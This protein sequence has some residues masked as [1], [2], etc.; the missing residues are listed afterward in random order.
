MTHFFLYC[1]FACS[2]LLLPNVPFCACY[3]LIQMCDHR[4][5][6]GVVLTQTR[7]NGSALACNV[8]TMRIMSCQ[9]TTQ[10]LPSFTFSRVQFENF[11]FKAHFNWAVVQCHRCRII[12][13]FSSQN[14]ILLM[15]KVEECSNVLTVKKL[16][17]TIL[18]DEKSLHIQRFFKKIDITI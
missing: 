16:H 15:S 18:C 5:I 11:R 7:K 12:E 2:L 4:I 6:L 1:F 14:I 8:S 10:H 9:T 3:I 17:V 13:V